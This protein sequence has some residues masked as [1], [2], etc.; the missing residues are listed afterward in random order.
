MSQPLSIIKLLFP[1][2]G[3]GGC[4]IALMSQPASVMKLC[5]I[6]DS[7]RGRYLPSLVLRPATF[8]LSQCRPRAWDLKSRAQAKKIER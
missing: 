3:I 4:S 8:R 2:E 7:P 5:T 6:E 1:E